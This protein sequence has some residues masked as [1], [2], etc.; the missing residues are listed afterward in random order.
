MT[1]SI[2]MLFDKIYLCKVPLKIWCLTSL[3]SQIEYIVPYLKFWAKRSVKLGNIK[4][5]KC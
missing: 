5:R 4:H 2:L 1:L 3:G